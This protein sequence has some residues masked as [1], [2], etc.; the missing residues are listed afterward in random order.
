MTNDQSNHRNRPLLSL[1]S[2]EV[3]RNPSN[4]RQYL[5]SIE[6]LWRL[7]NFGSISK[8]LTYS[9]PISACHKTIHPTPH[10]K[11]AMSSTTTLIFGGSGKVA[12][13]IT[14]LLSKTANHTVHSI[15]RKSEQSASIAELGGKPIVQSIEDSSVE[16]MAAT[17]KSTKASNIIWSAG[18]GGGSVERTRAVDRDGA[19][20]CMDAAALAGVKRFVLVSAVDVRD[21]QGKPEPE[22]YDDGDRER[23]DSMWKALGP[24]MEAKLAADRSL[25]TENGRR[26]LDYTIVRPGRLSEEA[27]TGKVEA[28]K[29]HLAN[30]IPREDVARVV[31]ECLKQTGT[32]GLA[33]DVVG[34]ETAIEEAVASVVEGK[35]D[36]FEERY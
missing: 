32:I 5:F 28:G 29:V 4:Y 10:P 24:Y 17:I 19:I 33:F 18:A 31:V 20:R 3:L 27:A 25:V 9:F 14:S 30:S 35:V 6:N 13:H 8:L 11:I 36:T 26:G 22:W 12:R 15:I 21:R 1:F 2:I 7:H 16:D 23:S 34:G